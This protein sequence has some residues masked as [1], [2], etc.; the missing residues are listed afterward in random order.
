M[1]DRLMRRLDFCLFLAG[2]EDSGEDAA[3]A[4]S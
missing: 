4:T 2:G 1:M 3:A